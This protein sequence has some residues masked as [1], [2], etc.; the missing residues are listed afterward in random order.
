MQS[1]AADFFLHQTVRYYLC[2]IEH[3][4]WPFEFWI[5]TYIR[6]INIIIPFGWPCSNFLTPFP[7]ELP[8][9]PFRHQTSCWLLAHA[10]P[11]ARCPWHRQT[12]LSPSGAFLLLLTSLL[13]TAWLWFCSGSKFV[14][15][16][17]PSVSCGTTSAAVPELLPWPVW[18]AASSPTNQR[19]ELVQLKKFTCL[20]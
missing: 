19:L 16:L 18:T 1:L 10:Q 20:K 3:S 4:E 6:K 17:W 13:P 14:F 7:P 11:S 9:D 8:S 12:P 5:N 2:L 15:S